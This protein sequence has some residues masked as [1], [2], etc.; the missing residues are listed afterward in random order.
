MKC[1]YTGLLALGLGLSAWAEDA[2]QDALVVYRAAQ[3]A[4]AAGDSLNAFFLYGRAA[5]LDP[6]NAILALQQQAVKS[7]L[8]QT[9]VAIPGLDPALDPE[10]R[11]ANRISLEQ[12]TPSEVIEGDPALAPLRLKDSTERRSFDLRGTP[13]LVIEGVLRAFG[14]DTIF[15]QDFQSPGTVT[16]R[17]EDMTRDEALHT[18]EIMTTSFFVPVRADALLVF[19]DTTDKRNNNAPAMAAVIPIPE[20]MN[21]QEA[22]ELASGVQQILELRRIAVDAGRRLI[23]IRDQ[24]YKVLAARR[25]VSDLLRLRAQVVVDVELLSSDKNSTLSYGLSLQNAANIV[26]FTNPVSL[27]RLGH[28]ATGWFGLTILNSSVVATMSRGSTQASLKSE[29]RALDGQQVQLHIGDRY[30]VITG[31]SGFGDTS[32]PT[33]QFQDLG[34]SLQITPVVQD[35]EVTLTIDANYNVLGG[36]SNNGIPIISGRKFQGTV[37]VPFGQSAIIAGLTKQEDSVT[38]NG[39]AGLESLPA[40]GHLFRRDTIV[41]SNSEILLIL[42]PYLVSE[43]AWMRPNSGVWMGTETKPPTFY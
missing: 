42:R 37:R 16:F 33:T 22:Q 8:L 21:V 29:M 27:A 14:I 3:K 7:R 1:F 36:G 13:R 38:T 23:F 5:T 31:L 24:Q 39:I 2:R 40:L 35:G 26:N 15:E 10:I 28:L 25:L 20:R 32:V 34:L 11:M 41:K 17:V 18:L 12:L 9:S 4:E 43:P 30:P 19:R 6:S